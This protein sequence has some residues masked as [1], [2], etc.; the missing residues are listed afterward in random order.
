M[1]N[2]KIILVPTGVLL[3]TVILKDTIW[4]WVVF[5]RGSEADELLRVI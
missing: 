1:L 2:G 3:S 4:D 5:K